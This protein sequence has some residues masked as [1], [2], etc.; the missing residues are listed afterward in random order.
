MCAPPGFNQDGVEVLDYVRW[1]MVRKRDPKSPAP[2]RVPTLPAAL[3]P[4]RW[5]MRCRRSI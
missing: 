3:A 1:V 2:S 5:A 4:T